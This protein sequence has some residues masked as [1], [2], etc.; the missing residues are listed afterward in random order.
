MK[1]HCLSGRRPSGQEVHRRDILRK[2]A[3]SPT[4][5]SAVVFHPGDLLIAAAIQE[6]LDA[7]APILPNG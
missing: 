3:L 2:G 5:G 1:G 4:P 6:N 7:S